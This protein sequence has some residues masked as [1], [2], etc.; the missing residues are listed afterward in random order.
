MIQE[1]RL[2]AEAER[3]IEEQVLWYE[4]DEERGGADLATR[5]LDLLEEGLEVLSRHPERYGFAPENGK[6][7]PDV[8][9]RQMRFKPWKTA[10]AWRILFVVDERAKQVVVLQIRHERR[11][12]LPEQDG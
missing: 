9:I 3:A 8:L 7:M 5:W 12:L 6:W 4:A 1:L 11:P 10:S 2:S